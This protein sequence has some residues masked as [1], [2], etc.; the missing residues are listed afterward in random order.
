[1]RR[2][3]DEESE[4]YLGPTPIRTLQLPAGVRARLD[5]SKRSATV[6]AVSF[7]DQDCACFG[8]NRGDRLAESVEDMPF[9]NRQIEEGL[10]MEPRNQFVVL[11]GP[12]GY[13][14]TYLLDRVK[15][16]YET[17]SP[18]QERWQVVLVNLSDTKLPDRREWLIRRLAK[19][20][21]VEIEA[22]QEPSDNDYALLEIAN[23]QRQRDKALLFLL[24]GVEQASDAELIWLR[25]R[26]P[27]DLRSVLGR[28]IRVILSGRYISRRVAN[29]G[30]ISGQVHHQERSLPFETCELSSFGKAV[31]QGI[32]NWY[33]G[34]T[35]PDKRDEDLADRWIEEICFLSGGHP[36]AIMSLA[37]DLVCEA[38]R[39]WAL[40]DR[41]FLPEI[42]RQ[43]LFD[44]CLITVSK[45]V[46]ERTREDMKGTMLNGPSSPPVEAKTLEDLYILALLRRFEGG[47]LVQ[48]FQMKLLSTEPTL[49][50]G[51]LVKKGLSSAVVPETGWHKADGLHKLIAL[52]W[53]YGSETRAAC[54]KAHCTLHSLFHNCVLGRSS[55]GEPLPD[56]EHWCNATNLLLSTMESL[57]HF[58]GGIGA[59]PKSQKQREQMQNDLSKLLV[60]YLFELAPHCGGAPNAFERLWGMLNSPEQDEVRFLGRWLL[61]DD[62]W[63]HLYD[64]LST[65]C[66]QTKSSDSTGAIQ[67]NLAETAAKGGKS[68]ERRTLLDWLVDTLDL[69]RHNARSV[70]IERWEKR[71]LGRAVTPPAFDD[72]P[73]TREEL[74]TLLPK[75]NITN[76]LMTYQ[77]L[78]EDTKTVVNVDHIKRLRKDM[79]TAQRSVDRYRA[80]LMKAL[81]ETERITLEQQK[82]DAQER[83]DKVVEELADIIAYLYSR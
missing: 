8:T 4:Y 72:E 40:R 10:L 49:L 14:K 54:L 36:E 11:E 18:F 67:L 39:G 15:R 27:S 56:R 62:I 71:N 58:L 77:S 1:M 30:N 31:V 53:R 37:K 34:P 45:R 33:Q 61:G 63:L 81:T 2:T 48:L 20:I 12:T 80:S 76:I 69:L 42:A 3:D 16:R 38:K 65:A 22:R 46:L 83:L 6:P 35:K 13:G 9:F 75:G 79:D 57:Y 52:G 73:R 25:Y 41:R 32:V 70:L 68:M 17:E 50:R 47:L 51:M 7:I 60:Q 28:D 55:D 24:D 44:R 19:G 59:A 64:E 74:L 26:L 5:Y 78:G 21:G 82:D 66:G 23:E 29:L 43:E